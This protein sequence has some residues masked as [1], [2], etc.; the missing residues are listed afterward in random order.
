MSLVASVA[1]ASLVVFAPLVSL[2]ES[3]P[4]VF[5]AGVMLGLPQPVT[6]TPQA[7]QTAE[8]TLATLCMMLPSARPSTS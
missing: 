7:T 3:L 6:H 1:L 2:V 5:E 8:K 4:P